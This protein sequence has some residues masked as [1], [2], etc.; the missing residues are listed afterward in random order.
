MGGGARPPSELRHS[1]NGVLNIIYGDSER[2]VCDD[3]FSSKD[4]EVACRELYGD[5]NF[6]NFIVDQRCE[7]SDFWLDDI[8]CSGS[9]EKIADCSHLE[10]GSHNCKFTR[11]LTNI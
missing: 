10:W 11:K 4:A 1:R 7:H 5:S 8:D 2:S 6:L 9:E 3:G